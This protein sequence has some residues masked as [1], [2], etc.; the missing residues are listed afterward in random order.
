MDEFIRYT[1]L[2]ADEN[3]D[4][5]EWI[6]FEQFDLVRNINKRGAFSSIY[7]AV[8]MEGPR[9]N[10]DEEA[11]VWTRIGPT[12]VILKRLDNSQNINQE[13]INQVS[14][15]KDTYSLTIDWL[16][17]LMNFFFSYFKKS[18]AGIINAYKAYHS[19]IALA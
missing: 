5:L 10:L 4:Y 1:Q 12:K 11:E 15:I 2:N 9:C 16:D 14:I 8:W 19:Q 13:F 7:S 6:D 3:I 18:C 17:F